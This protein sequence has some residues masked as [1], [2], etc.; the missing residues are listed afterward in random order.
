MSDLLELDAVGQAAL[1]R[2]GEISATE[3]VAAAIARAERVNPT[4]NAIVT[5]DFDRAREL[6]DPR[7]LDVTAPPLHHAAVARSSSGWTAPGAND[8]IDP[9]VVS[10]LDF[11]SRVPALPTL[12]VGGTYAPVEGDWSHE[13]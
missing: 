3:L 11:Q 9:V 5:P 2:S 12:P 13:K 4:L 8:G 7:Q 10:A 1:V 6:A